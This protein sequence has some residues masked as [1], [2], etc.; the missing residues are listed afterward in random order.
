ML[1]VMKS[2]RRTD[3]LVEAHLAEGEVDEALKTL[4]Q[5]KG[6]GWGWADL[7]IKVAKAAEAVRPNA[8]LGIYTRRAESLIQTGGR[9]SYQEACALLKRV[10]AIR[11]AAGQGD[12]WGAYVAALRERNTK[13]RALKEELEK[14]G[15]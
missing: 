8:A 1:A 7:E 2:M 13:L 15:L 10:K 14:A 11:A 6:F 12:E 3:L 4:R 9:A 5:E